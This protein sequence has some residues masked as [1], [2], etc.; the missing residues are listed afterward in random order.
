MAFF[1]EKSPVWRES[2]TSEVENI[3]KNS[4]QSAGFLVRDM[5]RV[6]W[7]RVCVVLQMCLSGV[8]PASPPVKSY[9]DNL[10]VKPTAT[11]NQIKENFRKMAVKY[12]PDKNKSVDA[13][14]KFKEIAEG[15]QKNLVFC[16]F[17]EWDR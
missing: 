16:L 15:K 4:S 7:V 6:F 8:L 13:E 12:H 14:T 10:N 11:I 17:T 3:F 1:L 2:S 9:Y 5:T